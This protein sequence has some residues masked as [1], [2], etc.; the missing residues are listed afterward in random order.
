M[1]DPE[2]AGSLRVRL[3]P[4]RVK[5]SDDRISPTWPRLI[6]PLGLHMELLGHFYRIFSGSEETPSEICLPSIQ[7]NL[8]DDGDG[9][10]ML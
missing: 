4:Q 2:K 5:S 1:P 6:F 3:T 7:C 8:P 9:F 10:T